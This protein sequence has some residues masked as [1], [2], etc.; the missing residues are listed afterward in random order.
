ML[1]PG[2]LVEAP[3]FDTAELEDTADVVAAASFF[4]IVSFDL[5]FAISAA[6]V[7]IFLFSRLIPPPDTALAMT[8]ADTKAFLILSLSGLT[9]ADDDDDL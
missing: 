2:S 6:E 5:I 8:D 7:A 9:I 4:A 1:L 3:D